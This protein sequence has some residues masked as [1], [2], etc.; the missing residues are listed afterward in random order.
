[1]WP[2]LQSDH[3]LWYDKPA[4]FFEESLVIG[5]GKMGASVFGGVQSDKIYLN[6]L[7]LWSGE[8]VDPN[9]NPDAHTYIPA[10]REALR[11]ENYKL[12]DSLNKK[13]QGKFSESYAPLGTMFINM[14]HEGEP[15]NY[16]R[17]LDLS[18]ATTKVNY[19][20]LGVT[21]SREYF[22]SYPD[23]VMVIKLSASKPKALNFDITFES[24][25]RFTADSEKKVLKI[26]G[27][28]PIHTEPS[29]RGNMPIEHCF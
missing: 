16:Y 23:K 17:E 25:L 19:E 29:Y 24:P 2:L 21:Y 8:P 28:A 15:I 6:D 1:M 10:I 22:I 13:I 11:N 18:T 20:I 14:K 12:A 26:H 3:V 27:Y 7:T 9:M 4:E 5:N